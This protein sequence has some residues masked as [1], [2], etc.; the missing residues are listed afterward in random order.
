MASDDVQTSHVLDVGKPASIVYS[1]SLGVAQPWPMQQALNC[2]AILFHPRG[3]S[4]PGF[5]HMEG[6]MPCTVGGK[7]SNNLHICVPGPSSWGGGHS[8]TWICNVSAHA[9]AA[10]GFTIWLVGS[11]RSWMAVAV[12]E[13]FKLLASTS[14]IHLTRKWLANH[15]ITSACN[16]CA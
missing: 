8:C 4:Q 1:H 9:F 14:R 12:L 2:S 11:L 6:S 5:R 15:H 3:E 13:G 7:R 10:L 16:K